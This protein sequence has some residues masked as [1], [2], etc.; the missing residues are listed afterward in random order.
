MNEILIPGT[1]YKDLLDNLTEG[2]YFVDVERRI[3]YWNR[4]AEMISGY[5]QAFVLGKRCM[6]NIL[7][8]IND[9]GEFSAM[10]IAQL[11]RQSRI[12]VFKKLKYIYTTQMGTGFQF[13]FGQHQS[14]VKMAKLLVRLKPLTIYQRSS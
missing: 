4:G 9:Q 3:T 5:Q 1:F 7:V 14:M 2:V 10:E 6:D 11:L 12:I 13:W 8:H